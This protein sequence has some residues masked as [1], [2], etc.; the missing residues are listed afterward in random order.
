MTPSR[1]DM[2]AG[3]A[4]LGLTAGLPAVLTTILPGAL[5]AA[6][7]DAAAWQRYAE[8]FL[9]PEGRIVDSG[10]KGVSHSEGQGYG[11]L[12]AVAGGD[13]PAFDRLW[14]WTQRT[15]MVRGDGLAA[16]RWKPEEGV[17]D[18]NN[19]ADGDMLIAW[20]LMRAAEQWQAESYR[21]SAL[22]IV[23]ALAAGLLVEQAGLTVLLPGR[24]GFRKGDTLVLNPSYWIFPAIRAFAAL[25]GGERW[26]RLADAGLVLL[27][28]ARFGS[29]QLPPDWMALDAGGA[30]TPAEGF[31]KQYGY[32]AVRV[33]LYLAWDGYRD[34]YYFR[35]YAALA[36]KFG[37]TAI[38][39]TVSLPQGTTT[40]VAASV[41]ML[42]VYRLACRIAGTGNEVTVP[43]PAA[44][45][46]Y[47]STT[48]LHLSALAAQSL[49]I[50]P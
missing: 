38:P 34:P 21:A 27:S 24:E 50:D 26:G 11:M 13:R 33:P 14:G 23:N 9:Q 15:L 6:P 25:P 8:R 2:L 48:L 5:R 3:T 49:G 4:S 31:K 30:V 41:G 40:Q 18:R 47:Y 10:N 45:E 37:G 12:L 29:Y 35:P 7:F 22:S 20:A 19:A 39:A 42:A 28:K 36:T 1:R 43:A 46:D 17:T 16:W 44:D 32:D